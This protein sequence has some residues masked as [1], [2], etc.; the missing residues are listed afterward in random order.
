[1]TNYRSHHE[2]SRYYQTFYQKQLD[3]RQLNSS[4]HIAKIKHN[5]IQ[6]NAALE[7]RPIYTL[8]KAWSKVYL[9]P[10]RRIQLHQFSKTNV[11]LVDRR[12]FDKRSIS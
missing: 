9:K 4:I 8:V 3:I 5:C 2:Q 1:M 7:I 12:P 6:R 11:S 10:A